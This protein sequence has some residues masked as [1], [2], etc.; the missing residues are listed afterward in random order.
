MI[1]P[2]EGHSNS[3]QP[4][5]LLIGESVSFTFLLEA[6]KV[7]Q[8]VAAAEVLGQAPDALIEEAVDLC[9]DASIAKALHKLG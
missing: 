9:F 8:F 5:T 6:T 2:T 3:H 7:E 4:A 1:T